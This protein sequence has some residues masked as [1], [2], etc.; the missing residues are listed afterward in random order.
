M[1]FMGE[2]GFASENKDRCC[3]LSN[4]KTRTGPLGFLFWKRRKS[5]V[6]RG[7]EVLVDQWHPQNSFGRY[8][9]RYLCTR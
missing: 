3:A 2:S 1:A 7:L 6:Y 5:K 9:A 8:N 4:T